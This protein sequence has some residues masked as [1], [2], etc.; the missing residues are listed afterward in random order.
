LKKSYTICYNLST[1]LYGKLLKNMRYDQIYKNKNVWGVRP[2]DLLLEIFAKLEPG[3]EFLDLG[4]G[5]GRDSLFMLKNGFKVTAVDRSREG[6]KK[7]KEAM[8]ESS[9][10]LAKI[11][12]FCADI[13]Q[14]KIE[15]NKYST[16]NSYNALHFLPKNDALRTLLEIKKSLKKGGYAIISCSFI[17]RPLAKKTDESHCYISEGQLK[18]IF[19][20]FE[21]IFYKESIMADKGHAG[22]PDPHWHDVVKIIA[23][24]K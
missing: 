16:I 15:K 22:C 10:P 9:L 18:K 23:R 11:K 17:K 8:A 24:K 4:C 6:I 12:L 2:N 19:A 13:A 21:M 7:I 5:Q 14:F 3:S 20:D 1:S